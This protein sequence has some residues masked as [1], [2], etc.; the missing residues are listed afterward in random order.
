[1]ERS[2]FVV[3]WGRNGHSSVSFHKCL[4]LLDDQA[5]TVSVSSTGIIFD[6]GSIIN[7]QTVVSGLEPR[8]IEFNKRYFV[9]GQEW[10]NAYKYIGNTRWD[11]FQI[12][13]LCEYCHAL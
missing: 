1:M 3:S 11:A 5:R 6:R 12:M 13:M 10:G 9:K 7:G 4:L 2:M 8:V